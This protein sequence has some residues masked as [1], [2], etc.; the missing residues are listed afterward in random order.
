MYRIAR[1]TT[2]ERLIATWTNARSVA[3][4]YSSEPGA[5]ARVIARTASSGT[6]EAVKRRSRAACHH[7]RK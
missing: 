2:I 6:S 4:R 1:P 3:V 7:M 5:Y